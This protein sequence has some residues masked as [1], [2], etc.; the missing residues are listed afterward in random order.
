MA[1]VIG[2]SFDRPNIRS[3]SVP[4]GWTKIDESSILVIK[5]VEII[6]DKLLRDHLG[7]MSKNLCVRLINGASQVVSGVNVY[8]EVHLEFKTT[9]LFVY[10]KILFPVVNS[11]AP[12][13]LN[14]YAS[15]N[16]L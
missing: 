2:D 14:F 6:M 13:I 15:S 11:Q 5:S 3:D 4:G 9:T 12:R 8:S 16:K 1:I 10:S 7:D